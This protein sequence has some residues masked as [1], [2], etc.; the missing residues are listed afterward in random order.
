MPTAHAVPDLTPALPEAVLAVAAMALL[1]L[2]VFRGD[3]SART[4]SW[5]AVAAMAAA[6]V[7]VITGPSDG[8]VTFAGMFVVDRFAVFMKVLVLIG[9]ALALVMS[10]AYLRDEGMERF[11]FPVLL[12]LATLGM[13]MM[14]SANDLMALYLGLELQS[15]ALYVV[16]A[17]KRESARGAEAGLKYFVLGALSSGMLLYGCSLIYGTTGA[18]DFAALSAALGVEGGVPIGLV[19]GLVFLVSGLAFKISAVPFHMWTPDVYEGAP[20]PVTAFLAVAPKIAAVALFLRVMMSPFGDLAS[21]WQQIIVVVSI[22]SM[23]LG[24]FAAIRQDNM[25]R[26]MAYS[27]IGHMG[28]ALV[29]LAAGTAEGVRGAIVYM[30]IYLAMNV[31]TFAVIL[32]MKRAGAM[33]EGIHDLAGLARSRPLMALAMGIFMFSLAGIPPLAGFF[34]QALRVSGGRERGALRPRRHRRAG[35]RRRRVL[36]PAH[37]QDHVLRRAVRGPRRPGGAGNAGHPRRRRRLHPVLLRPSR[38]VSSPA[39]RRPPWLSSGDVSRW[40]VIPRPR[41]LR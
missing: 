3:G 1:M 29:G 12:V 39:P 7:L 19:I 28:Y 17:F 30:T 13:L 32:N 34:R 9:S 21:Q 41:A 38:S 15:L 5:L 25:K 8:V 16:A 26:L 11:E 37:R 10:F 35:E 36:L 24:A 31:G 40:R 18:T 20:T 33:V 4:V 27:S 22:A 2:G 6:G 14:I 23:A